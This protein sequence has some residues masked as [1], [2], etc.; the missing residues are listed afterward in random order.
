MKRCEKWFGRRVGHTL[1]QKLTRLV[2]ATEDT[3]AGLAGHDG[4]LPFWPG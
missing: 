4:N 1:A 3:H 2:V